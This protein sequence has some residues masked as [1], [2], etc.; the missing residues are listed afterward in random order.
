MPAGATRRS[1]RPRVVDGPQAPHVCLFPPKSRERP[2]V[3]LVRAFTYLSPPWS[4]RELS[5]SLPVFGYEQPPVH[6]TPPVGWVSA[7]E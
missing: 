7:K 6:I 5:S 3:P 1:Y 2:C 4:G